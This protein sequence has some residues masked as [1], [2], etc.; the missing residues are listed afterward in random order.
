M[1]THLAVSSTQYAHPLSLP[2]SSSFRPSSFSSLHELYDLYDLYD[3][4]E[5]MFD[6]SVFDI[7]MVMGVLLCVALV[8]YAIFKLFVRK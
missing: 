1:G 3:S 6:P 2:I 5:D 7:R 4:H 8:A